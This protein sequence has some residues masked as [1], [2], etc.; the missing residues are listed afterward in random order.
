M[1]EGA[2]YESRPNWTQCDKSRHCV[3]EACH[4]EAA[5]VMDHGS[6]MAALR[7]NMY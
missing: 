2:S 5:N 6:G 1:L 3:T 4:R 7:E